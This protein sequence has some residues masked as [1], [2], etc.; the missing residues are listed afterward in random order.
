MIESAASRVVQSPMVKRA[1][2]LVNRVP[3][4]Y[5]RIPVTVYGQR[6]VART[7]DRFLALWFWKFGVF[8]AA[9]ATVARRLC[10]EG[11]SVLDIGANV[12]FYTLLFARAVGDKGHVWAFEP[13][14]VNFGTL[15]RNLELNPWR[16]VTAVPAAV[17]TATGKASLYRS[18]FHCDH[19]VYPTR[20]GQQE[21]TVEMVSID[22]FLPAGQ[23]IDLVKMDI[24][25][26]EGM[27][28]RGMKRT[29]ASNPGMV[30]LMEFWPEG[31]RETGFPPEEVISDLNDLGFSLYRID[32][33]T[34]GVEE[35]GDRKTLLDSLTGSGYANLLA[36]SGGGL[37]W[38][39]TSG[40]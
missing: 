12:G 22:E 24:Q 18:S 29:L 6:M 7:L 10:R 38:S 2:E 32:E 40:T 28:L 27:A 19:R 35:V 36:A 14:P 9:E 37:P 33:R 8:G 15:L 17:G 11:M 25:G 26:A 21:L 1:L 34:G 4:P 5:H 30:I 39:G 13:D 31:L 20:E 16:N 23:R 3:I